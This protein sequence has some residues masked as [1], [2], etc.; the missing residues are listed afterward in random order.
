MLKVRSF[1]SLTRHAS[2]QTLDTIL[3]AA[4]DEE[5]A[6]YMAGRAKMNPGM[7]WDGYLKPMLEAMDKATR[8][9]VLS[10]MAE[11][12]PSIEAGSMEEGPNESLASTGDEKEDEEK[13]PNGS[14]G[15]GKPHS[16]GDA[17]RKWRGQDHERIEAMTKANELF[18]K[19]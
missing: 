3:T 13:N 4:T 1:D 2:N 10:N 16:T 17:M 11:Y 6:K 12:Q 15:K 5:L 9:E 14:I 19:K 8:D 7:V 18:W